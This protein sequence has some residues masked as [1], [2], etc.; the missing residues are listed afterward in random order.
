MFNF[1]QRQLV[2][3]KPNPSRSTL[4][5]GQTP[6]TLMAKQRCGALGP[7]W[8]RLRGDPSSQPAGATPPC[9]ACPNTPALRPFNPEAKLQT[10]RTVTQNLPVE[11][12]L[13]R[14]R[15]SQQGCSEAGGVRP[16]SRPRT[17]LPRAARPEGWRRAASGLF[18]ARAPAPL[19]TVEMRRSAP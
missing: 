9:H 8:L 14:P 18:L 16:A 15:F 4:H 19:L 10:K 5:S 7:A 17:G 2:S 12:A 11:A 6:A 13:S 3:Q 1:A